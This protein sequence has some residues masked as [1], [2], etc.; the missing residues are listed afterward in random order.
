[1]REPYLGRVITKAEAVKENPESNY[2]VDYSDLFMLPDEIMMLS[3]NY[4]NTLNEYKEDC[5]TIN[6]I[7]GK[8]EEPES[9][10]FGYGDELDESYN[11][12]KRLNNNELLSNFKS[13]KY[14]ESDRYRKLLQFI[15]S[16][17]FQVCI[18]DIHSGILIGP[19]STQYLNMIIVFPLNHTIMNKEMGRTIIL[20]SYTTYQETSQI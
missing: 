18:L 16:A 15:E 19:C 4:T 14:L 8:L 20:T 10:I 12:I 2:S 6:Y 17:P 1:M 3:F 5:S 13:S 9:V 7:H 11:H